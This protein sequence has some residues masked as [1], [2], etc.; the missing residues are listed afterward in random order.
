MP[1]PHC[2]RGKLQ[3]ICILKFAGNLDHAWTA[4]TCLRL[5]MG[6]NLPDKQLPVTTQTEQVVTQD[7][8]L[9]DNPRMPL[10]ASMPACSGTLKLTVELSVMPG[11]ASSRANLALL[12]Q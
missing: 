1:L 9:Q 6:A 2:S 12:H 4:G 8:Q 3:C 11:K 10:V 5:S 7:Q